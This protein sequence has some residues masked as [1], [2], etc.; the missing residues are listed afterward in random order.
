MLSAATTRW[1]GDVWLSVDPDYHFEA[2]IRGWI[3]IQEST[4]EQPVDTSPTLPAAITPL[5]TAFP[6]CS[7]V[8][9][10]CEGSSALVTVYAS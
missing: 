9:I 4:G 10:V 1:A 7:E 3:R 2:S 6:G 5:L 8:A